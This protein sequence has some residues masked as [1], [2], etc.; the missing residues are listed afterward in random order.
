VRP[1]EVCGREDSEHNRHDRYN[2]S[3]KG[4]LRWLRYYDKR[5][6]DPDPLRRNRFRAREGLRKRRHHALIRIDERS[7]RNETFG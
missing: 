7:R 1:C 5:M 6:D 3:E 4:R 2:H